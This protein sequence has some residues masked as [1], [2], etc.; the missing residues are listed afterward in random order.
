MN[1]NVIYH[2]CSP[3]VFDLIIRN[4]TIRLS[5]I[6]KTND[7]LE[8]E[9][10]SRLIENVLNNELK[11][12]KIEVDLRKSYFYSENCHCHMDYLMESFMY[13]RKKQTLVACMSLADDDL[14]QWR[15]YGRD[16]CGLAI[17]FDYA[18]MGRIFNV[19]SII[20]I[21]KVIYKKEKQ[22][23]ELANQVI[24]PSIKYIKERF[25]R[26]ICRCTDSFSEY[27]EEEFDAFT[28][29]AEEPLACSV[30]YIKNPAFASEKE[31]RIIYQTNIS[32][33]YKEEDMID[34]CRRK[35][36]I[37]HK[38]QFVLSP[39]EYQFRNNNLISYADLSFENL[40][41]DGIVH[42]VIIGPKS[43]ICEEDL[44]HYLL[45]NGYGT[46]V[47]IRKSKASYR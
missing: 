34:A 40:I 17:G 38:G 2:Y 14:G 43:N 30:S 15:A 4:H 36:D 31:V 39:L 10:G 11:R 47:V 27:F 45:I 24:L 29:V 19:N 6:D 12:E 7:Y 20:A 5:N 26:H 41:K 44:K 23:K 25:D 13:Q 3:D 16:G 28:E 21:K 8:K 32:G 37:G 1:E 22:E 42:E 9:W 18:K 35:Q 33:D 46:D